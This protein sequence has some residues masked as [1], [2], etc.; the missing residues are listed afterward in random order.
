MVALSEE[1]FLIIKGVI[2][3]EY[4]SLLSSRKGGTGE[5]STCLKVIV[6]Q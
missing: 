6:G 5:I 3:G 4:G 1:R 2:R